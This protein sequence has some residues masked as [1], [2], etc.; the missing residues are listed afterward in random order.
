MLDRNISNYRY[1]TSERNNGRLNVVR[2]E[3]LQMSQV[4]VRSAVNKEIARSHNF[5]A[6]SKSMKRKYN[7]DSRAKK[8]HI[9]KL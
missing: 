4:N 1:S 7:M 2:S 9:K 8:H 3:F 6:I 5:D